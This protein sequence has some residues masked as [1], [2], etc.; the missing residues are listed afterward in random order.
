[1]LATLCVEGVQ[2]NLSK[3]LLNELLRD[4]ASAQD[5]G[6]PF[7]YAWLIILISFSIWSEPTDYQ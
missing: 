5:D 6:T 1:M 2:F 7:H 3:F 4:A